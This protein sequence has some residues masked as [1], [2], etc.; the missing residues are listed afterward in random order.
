MD[1]TSGYDDSCRGEYDHLFI[2]NSR[3]NSGQRSLQD[4]PWKE[5]KSQDGRSYWYA[6]TSDTQVYCLN[7]CRYHAQ[8]RETT[9][10]IPDSY[11][12]ALEKARQS[13]IVPYVLFWT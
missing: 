8:T 3:L 7:G 6:S 9:W 12:Q 4:L 1:K 2:I 10:E 11:K 5:H 13:I